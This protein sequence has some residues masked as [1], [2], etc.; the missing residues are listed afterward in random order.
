MRS[1]FPRP[2]FLFVFLFLHAARAGNYFQGVGPAN[3]FW[4]GGIVPYQFDTNYNISATE[5]N[6]IIAGLREWE[7]AANVKFVPYINQSNHVLLQF[8]NDGSGSGYCLLGNP[9]TMMLHGLARGLM[10][11]EAGHLLGLQHEHQRTDRDN[12]IVVNT[13]NVLG[14]TN[15]DGTIGDFLID[16]HSTP[17]G[18]YDLESVM[19]Y[20]P[21]NFTNGLGDAID[22][23]PSYWKYYHKLG[24]IAL[25]IG[26]RAAVSNLYG[27]PLT[28]LA[29]VVTNSADGGFGS[30]R[31]AIYYANDHP[32]TTISFNIPATDPGYSNGVCTISLIGELPPLVSA[33]TVIDGSTQPGFAGTPV[34]AID[35]SQVSPEAGAVSGLHLYGTN[36]TIR[37]LAIDNFSAGGIQFFCSDAVSNHVQGC[38]LG[39]KSDGITPAPNNY[40]GIFYQFGPHN[41]VMGGTNA[42]QR[43]VISGN[44]QY[45]ILINDTN[46]D[47][48]V[49][50]GNYIGVDA[51]GSLAVSNGFSGVGIWDGPVGT[52]IGGTNNGEGNVLSGNHYDGIS[53]STSNVYGVV[54]QGNYIGTDET[55]TKAVPNWQSGVDVFRGA[56]DMIIGGT[57]EAARNIIS[58]NGYTGIIINGTG[59]TNNL[60]Q[61]NYVGTDVTGTHALP[62]MSFGIG[63]W[64]G[65]THNLVGGINTGAANIASGNGY[66][67]VLISDA[68]TTNNTVQGNLIGTD[69][70]GKTAVPNQV[71]GLGVWNGASDNTIGGTIRSA[72]NVISG[73]GSYGMLIA[74]LGAHGNVVEGN[75]IGTDITGR[76]ALANGFAGLAVWDTATSNLIGGT[77]T[78][79]ANVISGN[80]TYGVFISDTNTSANRFEGNFIGPDITGTSALGNGFANVELQNGATGNFIG[81]VSPGAGNVIAFSGTGPGIVIY[82]NG[83]TNNAIRG[84]SIYD[85]G[86]LGIDLNNDGIT[87]N[88]A[89]Y[90]AGP[91][92]FQNY[93]VITNA[94][95][96]GSSTVVSGSLNSLP[97]TTFYLDFYGNAIADPSGHGQG[98]IYLGTASLTTDGTGNALFAFTNNAGNNAGQYLSATATSFGGD[99]SEF[100]VAVLVTNASL[101]FAQFT[102]PVV[103]SDNGPVFHLTLATNF[104]Y[105]IQATTNLA[106]NPAPWIDL[107][108]FTPATTS[109]LF[110]DRTAATVASRFYRVV[111]P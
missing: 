24:N 15:V 49:I 11:H 33:G 77:I 12:Y 43:N 46:S 107:T 37:A 81:G 75:L 73:N 9:A 54:I 78:G 101:P 60:I 39:V 97:N 90:L 55:G 1:P 4:P 17:F 70:T 13:A 102:T 50:R 21:D 27:A 72:A 30:L 99:T 91:N 10:C 18:P 82:D 84:N 83:T 38:Y 63:V 36:C 96:A 86:A 56:H 98:Q 31:A 23:L 22:P 89:G 64:G 93:P 74:D 79:A 71:F 62:N 106:G 51:S 47:N 85:N 35:G 45:G 52:I 34:V 20:G 61:G 110:T 44:L 26:D 67:G 41:N 53:L 58:G 94:Y 8:T 69:V 108:N 2:L 103:W 40:A 66:T 68:G 14:G 25:S 29:S 109:L 6:V 3:V 5:S 19:H 111:S 80:G 42:A 32:G 57:N 65:A 87:L 48:N 28:P 95:G 7:L 16:P 88:H 100:S 59:V 105:H 92:D 104:S 76:T